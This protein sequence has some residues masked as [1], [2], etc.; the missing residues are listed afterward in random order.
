MRFAQ[1]IGATW[2]GPV[3]ALALAP[4]LLSTMMG[5]VN[6]QT[7]ERHRCHEQCQAAMRQSSQDC[8]RSL[9]PCFKSCRHDSREGCLETCMQKVPSCHLKPGSV[10]ACIV[11]CDAVFPLNDLGVVNFTAPTG[12]ATTSH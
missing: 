6:G 4:A 12:Y 1:F 7:N 3:W 8:F 9:L 5:S 10:R 2:L 11:S